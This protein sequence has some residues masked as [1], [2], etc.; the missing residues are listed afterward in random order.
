MTDSPI[1]V[2]SG[3]R[4]V[5]LAVPAS[6][7]SSTAACLRAAAEA[8]AVDEEGNAPRVLY[9]SFKQPPSRLL[10]QWRELV[11]DD[12]G[13]FAI[14]DARE[15]TDADADVDEAGVTV[16][17]E[18]PDDLTW[19]G[20]R[21]TEHLSEWYE[22]DDA[23]VILCFDSLSALLQYVPTETLYRFLH[24]L[25]GRVEDGDGVGFYHVDPTIHDES[26]INTV[27]QLC[28]TRLD[29]DPETGEWA[30]RTF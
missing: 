6:A 3:A 5:L 2:P 30:T 23:P 15:Y 25:T 27:A 7:M 10:D 22:R 19:I 8:A 9:V 4:S 17:S 16:V 29:C 28:D 18:R 20:V 1:T 13:E 21:A 24:V 11:G 26:V 12:L 14:V